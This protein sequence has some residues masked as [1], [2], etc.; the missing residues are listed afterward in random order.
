MG[1]ARK[2]KLRPWREYHPGAGGLRSAA[3]TSYQEDMTFRWGFVCLA[4]YRRLDNEIGVGEVGSRF[5]NLAGA[6]RG[7]QAAVVN[8]AKYH[9]FQRRE[10]ANMGQAI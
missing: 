3:Y 9:A 4:C 7:D 2:V 6:S 5:F 1:L 8:E 10:A